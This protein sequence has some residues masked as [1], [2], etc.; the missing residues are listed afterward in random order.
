MEEP[1]LQENVGTLRVGRNHVQD[2]V[3]VQVDPVPPLAQQINRFV[4]GDGEHHAQRPA[5][6]ESGPPGPGEYADYR[7]LVHIL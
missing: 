1:P 3:F 5:R 2:R 4:A 7:L 6:V